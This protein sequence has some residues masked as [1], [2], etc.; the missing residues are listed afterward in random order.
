[1]PVDNFCVKCLFLACRNCGS[2]FKDVFRPILYDF[3]VLLVLMLDFKGLYKYTL[4]LYNIIL[5]IQD[6]FVCI[7]NTLSGSISLIIR[8]F[9]N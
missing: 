6:I 1:M 2:W 3:V 4:S 8:D 5:Y 9:N 7:Y